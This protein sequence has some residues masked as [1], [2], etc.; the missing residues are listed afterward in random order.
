MCYSDIASLYSELVHFLLAL[1]FCI[2]SKI[3]KLLELFV[4]KFKANHC[5]KALHTYHFTYSGKA[6]SY[7]SYSLSAIA[8]CGFIAAIYSWYNNTAYPSEFYG[9]R[10]FSRDHK[11]GK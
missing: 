9:P 11:L 8:K 7:L 2:C 5:I 4:W 10:S 6:Y 1:I 3:I